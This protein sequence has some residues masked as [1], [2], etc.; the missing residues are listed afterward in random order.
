MIFVRILN[1]LVFYEYN[2]IELYLLQQGRHKEL[3][4]VKGFTIQ[5]DW[6]LLGYTVEQ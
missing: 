6:E 1:S 4:C 2:Y 5:N 3:E